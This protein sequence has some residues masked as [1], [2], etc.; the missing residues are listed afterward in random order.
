MKT[1]AG[2]LLLSIIGLSLGLGWVSMTFLPW[3]NFAANKMQSFLEARGVQGVR[4]TLSDLGF[5]EAI[6]QDITAGNLS[7]KTLAVRYSL[8]DFLPGKLPGLTINGLSFALR[9][10]DPEVKA[11]IAYGYVQVKMTRPDHW[12]GNWRLYDVQAGSGETEM[13]AL[14][15]RGTL[16]AGGGA[17]S[18]SG[19]FKS[20]D[21]AWQ[22][23]F[24]F[25]TPSNKLTLIHATLPWK[26]G[27]LTVRDASIPLAGKQPVRL[28]LQV[29]QVSVDALMQALTGEKVSAT[30][31]VSG[32]LPVVIGQDG[33]FS[34]GKGELRA[35][36]PGTI[37]LP[38]DA[39]P[40]DNEQVALTRDI[41]KNFHYG[42]LSISVSGGAAPLLMALEGNNP[43][44]YDGQPVK[45]NV[46]LGGDVL[47]F[48]RQNMIFLTDPKS[49]LKQGRP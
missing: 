12:E 32:D 10:D 5:H 43:D 46:R 22:A 30:G 33:S 4:F 39:I 42:T 26:G 13:P 11:S 15:G 48:I 40:G 20:A 41:L 37:T 21:D 29:Q 6:L 36:G 14:E 16:K 2:I 35:N 24:N 34:F 23:E 17:L 3:K 7:L 45:I 27:T 28:V 31:S 47:D 18:L 9:S 49:M 44:M 8:L 25:E 38:A 19:R 1:R